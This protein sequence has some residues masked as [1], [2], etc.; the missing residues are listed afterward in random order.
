MEGIQQEIAGLGRAAQSTEGLDKLVK[1]ATGLI[2]C[3]KYVIG[4]A[5]IPLSAPLKNFSVLTGGLNSI[6]RVNDFISKPPQNLLKWGKLITLSIGNGLETLK[7]LH[8]IDLV[9]LGKFAEK[10][11]SIGIFRIPGISIIKDI[12]I[13][14]SAV[15]GI[16]VGV[17]T[18]NDP[19]LFLRKEAIK[20]KI[21]KF[22][23]KAEYLAQL[24]ADPELDASEYFNLSMAN[25]IK[26]ARFNTNNKV[27]VIA[28]EKSLKKEQ[29]AK[30]SMPVDLK[31]K[32]ETCKWNLESWRTL[33]KI[34]VNE[35]KETKIGIINDLFKLVL[36]SLSIA[37]LWIA[38]L[39]LLPLFAIFGLLAGYTGYRKF[40]IHSDTPR[41]PTD[42]P[43]KPRFA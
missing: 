24:A 10:T 20:L 7:F 11:C 33:K 30:G 25:R 42:L 22:E 39:T 14:I 16:V 29:A 37:T 35:R 18:L 36:V 9:N 28:R 43:F 40:C 41:D 32:I 3:S 38:P 5:L 17:Q 12:F 31:G 26:Y 8:M 15:L 6:N 4:D 2:D 27:D 19:K 13:G 1:F 23:I 21:E 34:P